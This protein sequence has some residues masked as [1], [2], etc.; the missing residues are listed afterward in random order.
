MI[1]C[2]RDLHPGN[3]LVD[4]SGELVLLDWD[5]V[6]PASPDRE[7]AR[8]LAE[9]HVE[10][11]RADAAAIARTLAAYRA[12]GGPGRVRDEYSFGMLIASRLNFLQSQASVALDLRAAPDNRNYAAAE[13]LDT[14]ARLPTPELIA[15]LIG[16]AAAG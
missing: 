16:L 15:E 4:G 13:I 11:G 9:W 1:T 10:D 6:G 3:V 14:L 7:L 8:L 5:D 2:H 12:A